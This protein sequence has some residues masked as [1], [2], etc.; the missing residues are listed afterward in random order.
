MHDMDLELAAI[1]CTYAQQ[2]WNEDRMICFHKLPAKTANVT[3]RRLLYT[4][5]VVQCK[6]LS[7]IVLVGLLQN[8][9]VAQ[10]RLQSRDRAGLLTVR[11]R[12]VFVVYRSRPRLYQRSKC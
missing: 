6:L 11:T 1:G 12:S 3:A 10:W 4:H 8:L 7:M 5:P 2:G 9:A